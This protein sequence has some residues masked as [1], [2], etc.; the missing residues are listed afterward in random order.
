MSDLRLLICYFTS[1]GSVTE[2][3]QLLATV[4]DC[5]PG[6]L[7]PITLVP[8]PH[9]HNDKIMLEIWGVARA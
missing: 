8:Q 4:A 1:G 3:E 5:V 2:T 9:M 6:V 7:P